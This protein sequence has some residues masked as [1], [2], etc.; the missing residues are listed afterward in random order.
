[1]KL[2]KAGKKQPRQT[3]R[4]PKQLRDERS[5]PPKHGESEKVQ[6]SRRITAR[7]GLEWGFTGVPPYKE[8]GRGE[9]RSI[10]KRQ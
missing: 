4:K 3:T 10:T 1:L 9:T 2:P 6:V 5:P 8:V 7:K